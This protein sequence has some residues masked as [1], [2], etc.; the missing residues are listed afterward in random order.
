MKTI[1]V[2]THVRHLRFPAY[3]LGRVRYIHPNSKSLAVEFE[4]E[5]DTKHDCAGHCKSNHARWT[6][7]ES[8]ELINPFKVGDKVRIADETESV[9]YYCRKFNGKVGTVIRVSE[10]EPDVKV[11]GIIY[12]QYVPSADLTLVVEEPVAAVKAATP[13]IKLRTFQTGS[14][15]DR[16]IK[17]LLTG[18][19]ITPLKARQ[20]FG[21]E[22]LA[23][24]ILEIRQAGHKIAATLRTDLNGKT[25]GAYTLR[26]T[27]RFGKKV[28]A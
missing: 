20:L 25:Y 16:I 9:D 14:Q 26:K 11:E 27:D 18:D 3:G 8:L 10:G 7:A 15:C 13:V 5:T 4:N 2:G 22:R 6:R 17:F 24:R 19:T 23:A 1:V 28:A 21:T 12:S